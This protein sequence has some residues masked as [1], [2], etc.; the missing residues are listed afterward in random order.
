[1][2]ERKPSKH[3]TIRIPKQ[4]RVTIFA[5]LFIVIVA[6]GSVAQNRFLFSPN[7]LRVWFFDIGQGDGMMIETPSGKQILVDAGP[8]ASILTKLGGVLW[9]WDRTI[10]AI[11]LTH[12]DADHVTGFISVLK[13]YR[14]GHVYETGVIANTLIGAEI[15]KAIREEHVPV[16]MVRAGDL[17]PDTH[18]KLE[19][20]WPSNEAV[21]HAKNDR[22]NSSIVIRL[23]YGDTTALLTGD[24]EE[25]SEKQFYLRVG[26]IDVLKVGHHGSATAT[27]QNLLDVIRPQIA[28]I[29]AGVQNKYGHPH[30]LILDRLIK[31]HSRIFRT[32]TQG[33]ILMTSDGGEPIVRAHPLLF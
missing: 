23:T 19:T 28:I 33:D 6:F 17:I 20:L 3:K 11:V 2:I 31:I 4:T 24:A 29:S 26:P 14:V 22:N 5:V 13:R 30:P 9:P 21:V 27:S 12:P 10:D 16:T 8:D 32:D 25:P 15:E 7:T 18:V 1:M